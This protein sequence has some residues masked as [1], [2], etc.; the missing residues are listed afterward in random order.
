MHLHPRNLLIFALGFLYAPSTLAYP[1]PDGGVADLSLRDLQQRS[2]SLGSEASFMFKRKDPPSGKDEEE[3]KYGTTVRKTPT[4]VQPAMEY[5]QPQEAEIVNPP[6][7][8]NRSGAV[9]KKRI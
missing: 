6:K 2:S 8:L 9:R 5:P 3:P 7:G 4:I 1:V